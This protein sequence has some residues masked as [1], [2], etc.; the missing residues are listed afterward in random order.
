MAC[1]HCA[2]T[3]KKRKWTLTLICDKAVGHYVQIVGG[4]GRAIVLQLERLECLHHD[5]A[6]DV[7]G[8]PEMARAES[9]SHI[10]VV[11]VDGYGHLKATRAQQNARRPRHKQAI[12]RGKHHV[13]VIVDVDVEVV[14]VLVVHVNLALC[15]ALSVA[16]MLRRRWFA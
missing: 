5:S 13:S 7:D 10:E 9:S 8:V 6:R 12:D 11:C 16:S 1:R 15:R 4:D 2:A 3:K 14:D